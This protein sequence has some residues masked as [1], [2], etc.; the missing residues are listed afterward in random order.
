[1]K[2]GLGG[3]FNII[4]KGHRALLDKAFEHGDEVVVGL[5]SDAMTRRRKQIVVPLEQRRTALESYLRTKGANWSVVIIDSPQASLEGR[6]DIGALVVSPETRKGGEAINQARVSQ[7]LVPLHLVVVPHVLADDFLPISSGRV[8]AGEIDVEGRLL[9]PL[10]VVVGSTNP[11]KIAAVE[12]VLG[13]FY[14][15]LKVTGANVIS[16]V[17]EQP[18]EDLTRRGAMMRA[19]AAMDGADLSVGLEA[20]VFEKEDGL[21]DIQYCAVLDRRGR[22]TLGHGMGF[23]YP[24]EVADLVREGITVGRAFKELYGPQRDGRG[25]GA[26][27]YLTHGVLTRTMLAEQAVLAAIVPRVSKELYPDL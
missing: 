1:M 14:S 20:G 24:P 26:I 17:P 21:Y 22:Y 18:R 9:R 8:I 27:C 7:G 4:H 2:I 13:R 25:D 10:R 11:I 12:N 5:T 19:A 3:T 6:T 16:G 15:S 23:R